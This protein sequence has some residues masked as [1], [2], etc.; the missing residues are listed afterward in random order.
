MPC[1]WTHVD[2]V[3]FAIPLYDTECG[4]TRVMREKEDSEDEY[5]MCP[6]CK[7]KI[8]VDSKFAKINP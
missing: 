8:V 6:Y 2:W 4:E 7:K 1:K 3:V 5:K